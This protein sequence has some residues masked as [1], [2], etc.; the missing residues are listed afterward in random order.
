MSTLTTNLFFHVLA[1]TDSTVDPAHQVLSV[2][3]GAAAANYAWV[4]AL[5]AN[6]PKG[7]VMLLLEASATDCR[8]RFKPTTSTA[9][10]TATNGLLVKAGVPGR[11]FYVN[12]DK[13]GVI[14]VIA[15]GAGTLQVQ[16]ASPIG[17]RN[18]V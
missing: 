7:T 5:G 18:T 3:T 13:H 15:T 11:V 6:A 10:T 4:T 17:L 1:P 2:V 12:P 16:V 9:A 8:V 14:D